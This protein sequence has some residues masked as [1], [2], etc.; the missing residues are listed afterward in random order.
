MKELIREHFDLIYL[1]VILCVLLGI[2]WFK[3]EIT[4]EWI[5]GILGA[6]LMRIRPSGNGA[7]K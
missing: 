6:I 2:F 3:P 1:L 4:K 5:A 7:V